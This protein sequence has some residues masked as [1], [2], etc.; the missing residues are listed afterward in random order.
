[1]STTGMWEELFGSGR[2]WRVAEEL[3]GDELAPAG[4]GEPEVLV[5]FDRGWF[6]MEAP[7]AY[8][9]PLS[10]N[11]GRRGV[12]LVETDDSGSSDFPRSRIAIGVHALRRARRDFAAIW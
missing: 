10:T 12:V 9:S 1:M 8:R 6:S 3:S 4:P 11:L 7:G 2:K 5:R